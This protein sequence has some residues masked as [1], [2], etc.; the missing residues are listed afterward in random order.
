[1]GKTTKVV[2]KIGVIAILASS[3]LGNSY[4]ISELSDIDPIIGYDITPVMEIPEPIDEE[5]FEFE[6]SLLVTESVLVVEQEKEKE[7][8]SNEKEESISTTELI[9]FGDDILIY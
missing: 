8:E 3:I 9:L 5:S 1:M 6:E 2:R 7:N 4:A